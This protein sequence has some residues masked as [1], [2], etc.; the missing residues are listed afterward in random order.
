MPRALALPEVEDARRIPALLRSLAPVAG[1]Q[2]AVLLPGPSVHDQAAV[3]VPRD[4]QEAHGRWLVLTPRGERELP[5][6]ALDRAAA[7]L[8]LD[9]LAEL[10]V[11]RANLRLAGGRVVTNSGQPEQ[12]AR[13]LRTVRVE[14]ERAPHAERAAEQPGLEHHVVARGRL[15]DLGRSRRGP[16][17]LGEHERGEV[18]LLRELDEPVESGA[19]RVEGRRPGLDVGDVREPAGDRPEQF[20]LLAR[21]P[22]EDA[23]LVHARFTSWSSDE[24]SVLHSMSA[25]LTGVRSPCGSG[26]RTGDRAPDVLPRALLRPRLRLRDHAGGGVDARGADSGRL[27]EVR[28]RARDGLLGVV[29]L[30]VG[31]E[32]DRA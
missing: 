4:A 5:P 21:R 18:D 6:Q 17:V 10:L 22:E 25:F 7:T 24:A 3:A 9:R 32:R 13:Q 28:A 27:R 2:G 1:R 31:D 15:A 16:V 20:R 19:S 29:G 26:H 11:D 30:R 8:G 12:I 14:D 23:R